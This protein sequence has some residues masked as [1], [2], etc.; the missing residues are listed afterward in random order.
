[1]TQGNDPKNDIMKIS[2]ILNVDLPNPGI[3]STDLPF[4]A[5]FKAN[6]MMD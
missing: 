6:S 4:I 1:M 5:I 3:P 2:L